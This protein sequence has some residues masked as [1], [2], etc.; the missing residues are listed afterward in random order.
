MVVS[1]RFNSTNLTVLARAKDRV[2]FCTFSAIYF[3]CMLRPISF[4]LAC[5]LSMSTFFWVMRDPLLLMADFHM[6]RGEMELVVN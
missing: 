3:V 5:A 6:R 2:D 4:T 1:F